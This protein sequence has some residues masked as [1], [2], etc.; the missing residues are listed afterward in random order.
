MHTEVLVGAGSAV[1]WYSMDM[2]CWSSCLL[3][4]HGHEVLVGAGSAVYWL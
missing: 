3:V 1:Y 4:Q 2:K